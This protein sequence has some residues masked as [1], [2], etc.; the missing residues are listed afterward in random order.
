MLFS[1]QK[2]RYLSEFTLFLDDLKTANPQIDQKQQ[3]G[4]ALLWDKAPRSLDEQQRTL[5]STLT[6]ESH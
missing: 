6:R 4:R 2:P 3:A 5:E 1:K